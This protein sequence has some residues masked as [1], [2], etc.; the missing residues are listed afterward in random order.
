MAADHEPHRVSLDPQAHNNPRH[1]TNRSLAIH[2][3]AGLST[4]VLTAT[5]LQPADLL[6]TRVQQSHSTSLLT[7]L[8]ILTSA[9][10]PIKTLW[11]GTL[12]S[13]LRTGVGSAL[14]FST[15]NALRQNAA[16]RLG[17]GSGKNN[18]TGTSSSSLPRLSNT[19][20]LLTGALARVGAGF[21]LMPLTVIKV[22]YE[23]NLYT[24]KSIAEASTSIFRGEGFRGFFTGFGAT[25]IRDAPYA[26]LYVVFYEQAKK[27]ASSFRSAISSTDG[28]TEMKTSASA[29]INFASGV[30]AAGLATAIT[31]PFDA[32]KTRLQLEPRKYR[33][34]WQ[35]T[36]QMVGNEGLRSL[37]QGLGLRM[38]RKALSS[39]LVWTI[40]EEVIR[41]AERGRGI[42]I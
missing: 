3:L 39:A 33:N 34:M 40:Y 1:P 29:P 5:V 27:Y 11:R 13:I 7:T 9:P 4:G 2:F 23:S 8:R 28:D 17:P 20:N 14:Y 10:Q 16:T 18:G 32:V 25:A 38:G 24:Y 41:A 6:K 15:L 42:I 30:L 37:F 21:V 19:A 22:R 31:N 35:A 36:R 26:G 12:P